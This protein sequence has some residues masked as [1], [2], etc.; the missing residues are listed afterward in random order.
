MIIYG[1][2]HCGKVRKSNEDYLYFP[3][4]DYDVQNLMI[5][6]DG[7]GG[8]NAGDIAS[9]IAVNTVV[10]VIK[11]F[12]NK[13]DNG[14]SPVDILTTA[15]IEANHR[16]FTIS[17]E[18]EK[19]YGM[20]TTMTAAFFYNENVIIAHVGD[21]R[22]YLIRDQKIQQITN[23][24]SLVEELIKNGTITEDEAFHHPQKHII[25]RALGTEKSVQIDTFTVSLHLEDIILLCSD[26][27]LNHIG[28]DE[29]LGLF[30]NYNYFDK[31]VQDLVQR[32]LD[33]GGNDN[34]TVVIG[35]N[36]TMGKR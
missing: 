25:T 5:V 18:D 12:Y 33:K 21:S 10:D 14:V 4:N 20:G 13:H 26:G 28:S 23:D 8:H 16:I 2:T 29:I 31:I 35:T 32:A 1:G 36:S 17:Q 24:H 30:A 22:A 7:V 15:L 6:A 27:L 34:I 19:Y 9:F 3:F 11:G